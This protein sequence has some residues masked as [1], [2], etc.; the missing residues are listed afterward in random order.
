MPSRTPILS[1][2]MSA[3]NAEKYIEQAIKSI[4]N[5]S[6]TDFELIIADDGSVDKTKTLINEFCADFRIIV[7]H[8]SENI[9]KTATINRLF[10]LSSGKYIT[11]HDADDY[12]ELDRFSQQIDFL[13]KNPDYGV[14]GTSFTTVDSNGDFFSRTLMKQNHDDII[15]SLGEGSQIHGPTAIVRRE[16]ITKI[17]EI[18]R[19][20][21]EN[22]YEDIDFLYRILTQ[23]KAYNLQGYLYNYRILSN[24]LC[25]KEVTVK[26][27]NLYKIVLY[28]TNQR[29]LN[30]I[31]DLDLGR[32]DKVNKHLH[33]ITE[34]YRVDPSKIYREAA[35][36]YMYWNLYAK[37]IRASIKAIKTNPRL[38]VNYNT[39]QYC[40]RKTLV[41]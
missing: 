39:L 15:D 11:I 27:R 21:F 20:Y 3:Y 22:N 41:G 30:G 8:N 32:V 13:E 24:S 34:G 26:N 36:Y 38:F 28:L 9:G 25:R 19:P 31:D 5:Q 35:S 1:V 33:S 40:L 2:L 18:Y 12:S 7:D 10:Y 23:A 6:F 14:C 4:L 37:A 29:F 16:Y 17:G